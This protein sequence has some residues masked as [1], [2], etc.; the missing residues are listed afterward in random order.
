MF[1]A[2]IEVLHSL[3]EIIALLDRGRAEEDEDAP[4]INMA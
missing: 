3:D 1:D 2:L 4:M